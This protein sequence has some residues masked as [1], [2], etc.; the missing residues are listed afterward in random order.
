MKKSS[1]IQS[2]RFGKNGVG[3]ALANGQTLPVSE[4]LLLLLAKSTGFSSVQQLVLN[5]VGATISY[6]EIAVKAGQQVVQNGKVVLDSTG[7]PRTFTKDHTR[8]NNISISLSQAALIA[9]NVGSQLAAMFSVPVAPTPKTISE[10]SGDDE[11]MQQQEPMQV[12]QPA[13]GILDENMQP[14]G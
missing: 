2:F 5:G 6:E 8:Y 7:N 12:A 4:Q 9:A 10:G 11:G 13:E 3:I 14:G 1:T